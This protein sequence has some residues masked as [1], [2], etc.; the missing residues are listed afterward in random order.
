MQASR[1]L[2]FVLASAVLFGLGVPLAKVL[3][4]DVPPASLAGLLYLGAFFGLTILGFAGARGAGK[5][6]IPDKS[7]MPWL[8][9]IVLFGGVL[10]PV[11]LLLG[12]SQV[13]G[14]AA[15]LLLN[16]EGVAT[17]LVAGAIFHE[18]TGRR[19]W[20]ALCCMAIAGLLLGWNQAGGS[21]SFTGL[22]FVVLA[23]VFWGLD[24]NFTRKVTGMDALEIAKVKC[25]FAGAINL[26]IG[27]L[28][29]SKLVL[30]ASLLSAVLVGT[31]SYGISLVLFIHAL[32]AFGAARASAFFSVAPF[33]G[34]VASVLILGES[35]GWNLLSAFVLMA[36]GAWLIISEKH[37][38]WHYHGNTYHVHEHLH[39]EE[40]WHEH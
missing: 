37:A 29:G 34:A 17:A 27:F 21:F 8:V 13:S 25:F 15:S 40:H 7:D 10:G 11:F 35:I 6:I 30:G 1:P 9:L 28:L 12:L 5:R 4:V 24:N 22:I 18:F 16:L 32:R 38:H 20:I 14:S 31:F 33:V 3:L 39:D 36:A 23:M 26:G 2:I 19:F